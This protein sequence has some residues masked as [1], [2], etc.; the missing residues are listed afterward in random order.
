MSEFITLTKHKSDKKAMKEIIAF[1]Y[2]RLIA[3]QEK[4]FVSAD[5]DDPDPVNGDT[6]IFVSDHKEIVKVIE[7]ATEITKQWQKCRECFNYHLKNHINKSI[8]QMEKQKEQ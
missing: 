1:H 7:S 5:P 8:P 3:I 6:E 2:S 4:I